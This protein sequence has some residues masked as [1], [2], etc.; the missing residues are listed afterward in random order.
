MKIINISSEYPEEITEHL[1]LTLDVIGNLM[2]QGDNSVLRI[3]LRNHHS[4]VDL[5]RDIPFYLL[6][7]MDMPDLQSY[8]VEDV[9]HED[10]GTL[11]YPPTEYLGFYTRTIFGY[12]FPRPAIYLCPERFAEMENM[13]AIYQQVLIAKVVLHELAH[14]W[15]DDQRLSLKSLMADEFFMCMEES[16]ANYMTLKVLHWYSD[17]NL[18]YSYPLERAIEFIQ[19]QPVNYKLG[20]DLYKCRFLEPYFVEWASQKEGIMGN[21][22]AKQEWLTYVRGNVGN[23]NPKELLRLFENLLNF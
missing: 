12:G 3:H 18:G 22:D 23:T 21:T 15:M 11:A 7:P 1:K 13:G 19:E 16:M 6:S 17:Q 20:Y 8:E 2:M 10:D 5:F 9:N 14:A 4:L